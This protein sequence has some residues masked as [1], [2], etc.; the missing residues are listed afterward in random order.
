MLGYARDL[1]TLSSGTANFTM[2]FSSYK[3]MAPIDQIKAVK[4]VT[5]F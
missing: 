5:G 1:R 3:Q 4:A 2:E